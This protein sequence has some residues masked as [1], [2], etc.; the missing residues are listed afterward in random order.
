MSDSHFL[1]HGENPWI[2][3]TPVCDDP[4]RVLPIL[5]VGFMIKVDNVPEVNMLQGTVLCEYYEQEESPIVGAPS[6]P[7]NLVKR[8]LV[9]ADM[10]PD[11]QQKEHPPGSRVQFLV[12][13]GESK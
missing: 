8:E 10:L 7:R 9:A 13:K 11:N 3:Y 5:G 2:E 12:A 6:K 4:I 1:N